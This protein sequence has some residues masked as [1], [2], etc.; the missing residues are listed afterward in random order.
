MTMTMK[1]K[2][3]KP[4]QGDPGASQGLSRMKEEW[5]TWLPDPD[6]FTP[7]AVPDTALDP[8]GYVAICTCTR[9]TSFKLEL[10]EIIA[11]DK[12]HTVEEIIARATMREVTPERPR[13][14]FEYQCSSCH[15][16][17][18]NAR[19][20]VLPKSNLEPVKCVECHWWGR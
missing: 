16:V 19:D 20:M 2:T 13:Q 10:E 8:W 1:R 12:P 14:S 9:C 5:D 15:R 4:S 7:P 17:T 11:G 18:S 3:R 6:V